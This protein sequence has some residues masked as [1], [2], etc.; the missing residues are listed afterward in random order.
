MGIKINFDAAGNPI[1]P[2]FILTTHSSNRLGVLTGVSGINITDAFVDCPELAFSVT[3]SMTYDIWDSI[4]DIK[5]IY[6]PEWDV[7][8]QIQVGIDDSDATIKNVTA[9]GLC[10]SELSQIKVFGLEFNTE[11]DIER[12]DYKRSIIYNPWDSQA[13]I[14]HALIEKAPHYRIGHVDESIASMQK[15]FSFDEVSLTDAFDQICEECHCIVIYNNGMDPETNMPAREVSFYDL[16]TICNHC[17]YRGEY[18]DICPKCESTDLKY[19][20][21]KDTRIF[22]SKDNLTEQV[23]Y[24]TD[25]DSVKNCF[26]LIAGDDI[27]TAAIQACNPNGTDYIWY[28]S[29]ELKNDM[30]KELVEKIESYNKLYDYYNKE[31][32]TV[33]DADLVNEYNSLIQKYKPYND[34]LVEI[35]DRNIVG[36]SSLMNIIYDI[37]DFDA[38]LQSSLMPID[39]A[40]D[41]TTAEKQAALLTTESLSPIALSKVS[42]YSEDVVNQMVLSVARI[43]IDNRYDVKIKSSQLFVP[44][45]KEEKC[46]WVG[47][48]TITN[49]AD[50]D[51]TADTGTIQIYINKDYDTYIRQRVEKVLA[52]TDVEDYD[53]SNLL[54]LDKSIDDFKVSI[55][56]YNISILINLKEACDTC[57]DTLQSESIGNPTLWKDTDG[58]NMYEKYYLN[59]YNKLEAIVDEI[60]LKTKE[61]N[62]INNLKEFIINERN[63][64][65]STLNFENYLGEKLWLIFCSYR[66]EDVYKNENYISDNLNNAEIFQNAR[67]FYETA[68]KEIF[69]SATLQHSISSDL[70]NLLAIPEFEP[71][72]NSFELGNWIRIE[73][74]GEIYRLRLIK[75]HID[76]DNLEKIE[77][78]FSDCTKTSDGI[79]DINSLLSKASSM[80]TSYESTKRQA[81]KGKNS[82]NTLSDWFNNG[83]NATLTKITDDIETQDVVLDNHG[84]L[85]RDYDKV[86]ESYSPE[87]MKFIN[88]V[89]ALTDDNWKTLKTAIGKFIY[90]DPLTKE[91]YDAYGV[92]AE[93]VIGNLI[94]GTELG[95]YNEAATMRFDQNGLMIYNDT[96]TFRVNPNSNILLSLSKNDE[97]MFWV[98]ENGMLHISGDG[99]GLDISANSSVTGLQTEF[100][101]TAEEIRGTI[102]DTKNDL[103]SEIKQTA[104]DIRTE[105]KNTADGIYS[106]IEQTANSIRSEVSDVKDGLESQIS[107]T[108]TEIRSEVKD[109]KEGLE[110]NIT[111]TATSIRAEISNINDGLNSKIEQTA[112]AIRSEVT[113]ADNKLQSSITETASQ[114]RSEVKDVYDGLSTNINE[115][116]ESIRAE[117]KSQY[118]GLNATLEVQA[119]QIQSL[120]EAD[121]GLR[122]SIT[123]K[124]DEITTKVENLDMNLSAK[125]QLNAE[126]ITNEVTRA[127]NE[128]KQ[129]YSK[130]TQTADSLKAEIIANTNKYDQISNTVEMD[131]NQTKEM[132]NSIIASGRNFAYNTSNAW[133]DYLLEEDTENDANNQNITVMSISIGLG[134]K[135]LEAGDPIMVHFD[136]K[137]SDD[138][139]KINSSKAS[140]GMKLTHNG[141]EI[142]SSSSSL[143]NI[144]SS[145]S[146]EGHV[147]FTFSALSEMVT[148]SASDLNF[149]I[150]FSYY[151]GTFWW[152]NFMAE[153]GSKE[154]S[155]IPAPEDVGGLND[156]DF[157][158]QVRRNKKEITLQASALE[159]QEARLTVASNKINFFVKDGDDSSSFEIT[160]EAINQTAEKINLKGLIT[161]SGLDSDA[162]KKIN[163]SVSSIIPYYALS[164]SNETAPDKTNDSLWSTSVDWD[165]VK[166]TKNFVWQLML[167]KYGDGTTTK[168]NPVCITDG[169]EIASIK[170][171]YCLHTS[172]TTAPVDGTVQWLDSCPDYVSGKYIWTRNY[173]TYTDG[174]TKTTNPI[175][176][177]NT[178]EINKQVASLVTSSG[179]SVYYSSSEPSA[180][181]V[182]G[183]VWYKTSGSD[184]VG[185]YVWS[186]T[187]QWDQHQYGTTSIANGTITTDLLAADAV[188]ASK[189]KV[190]SLSAISADLGT[191]TAGTITGTT[192]NLGNGT[193]YVSS[194]GTVTATNG[195]VG[196]VD[197]Y[198]DRLYN[199]TESGQYAW[200]L[201]DYSYNYTNALAVQK[202]VSGAWE[203]KLTIEWDGS[204]KQ[205]GKPLTY[206]KLYATDTNYNVGITAAGDRFISYNGTSTATGVITLGSS[207]GRFKEVWS[208]NALNTSSD[209]N[210]KTDINEFDSKY[211]A[212]YMDL[213]P[214][215]YM[216]KN[217]TSDDRH[218]R[219]HFG[220]IAQEV[221][222]ALK[223]HN[224]DAM[225]AAFLCCDDLEEPNQAGLTKEYS[226]RYGELISLTIHM[227][228]KAYKKISELETRIIELEKSL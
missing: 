29:K 130:I 11:D 23:T 93:T 21:G 34:E 144:L 199:K 7:W 219:I 107:Q 197:L 37:I 49:Y 133:E 163:A 129:I 84:I 51:L 118:E 156:Y 203:N 101:V 139:S 162:Q 39:D 28:I 54:K 155:W 192:I 94:L 67:E 27:M 175:Y 17:G 14:L 78:E 105:V 223:K 35:E 40:P 70:H 152:K 157:Q 103:S 6:C 9:K 221:E 110:S 183:D 146:R 98:D 5:L 2:T 61:Q 38:F 172:S 65:Q 74:D 227:V 90:Q 170:P 209:R 52:D 96:N 193:F 215:T 18:T 106:D 41:D 102:E 99:A 217:F 58:V 24:S 15:T 87:Q 169:K 220:L 88:S 140:I 179:K 64:I 117:A 123:Q 91:Y 33:I 226:L 158:T 210:L 36:Y 167:T 137:F 187:G 66:R 181:H 174:T 151:K 194:G 182:V 97:K 184:I 22:V 134:N 177:S 16:E 121:E 26:K 120:V 201:A 208:T 104:T 55:K 77:V 164:D 149:T 89:L 25:L 211:E 113:D 224:M 213:R 95:I 189:L 47:S 178:T 176:D 4:L 122:S 143:S 147:F 79:S 60:E 212:M 73:V 202:Y 145:S 171:Q 159:G 218:D 53:I 180:P 86:T 3:K 83:M 85:V 216:M 185:I 204:M 166:E 160:D 72:R 154:N 63:N 191:I 173:I 109:A 68:Q 138:F 45:N 69:K 132:I 198:T 100:S 71:L 136:A 32:I 116:A 125:I 30:P 225:D 153:V 43:I 112:S 222:D 148:D 124:Y 161:F 59:Y 165:K 111:Q 150:T 128:E 115:T 62:A 82:Y 12:D 44:E 20:Y 190:A 114:I 196:C 13:S 19:G 127:Q 205:Q 131:R 186:S 57:L 214:V 1:E 228:Q 135:G 81:T 119:G 48:F 50:E 10:Q 168:T 195:H 126:S 207:G 42:D 46:Q 80:T 75:F 188:T 76:Y 31:H 206:N 108:A 8:M 92:N 200:Y 56:P 142:Y 141:Q